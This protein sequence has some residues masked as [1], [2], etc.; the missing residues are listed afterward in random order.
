VHQVKSTAPLPVVK[1]YAYM[2][3][4]RTCCLLLQVCAHALQTWSA[5]CAATA[6]TSTQCCI[7]LACSRPSSTSA[8]TLTR[9]QGEGPGLKWACQPHHHSNCMLATAPNLAMCCVLPLGEV[10]SGFHALQITSSRRWY[11]A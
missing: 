9:A 1:Q 11:E 6:A 7:R 10:V 5:T 8:Q 3:L 4:Q 2:L